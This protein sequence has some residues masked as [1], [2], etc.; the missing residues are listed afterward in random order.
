MAAC[1]KDP[2]HLQVAQ[3][4]QRM[5]QDLHI[6]AQKQSAARQAQV[7]TAGAQLRHSWLAEWMVMG[8]ALKCVLGRQAAVKRWAAHLPAIVDVPQ[9]AACRALI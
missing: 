1:S 5:A 2:A 7:R 8:C 3:Q 4:A 9:A 6:F